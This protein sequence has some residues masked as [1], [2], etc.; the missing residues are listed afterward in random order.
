MFLGRNDLN[1]NDCL[2]KSTMAADCISSHYTR[3]TLQYVTNMGW[4]VMSEHRD[5]RILRHRVISL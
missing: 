3:Y 1:T 4:T 5:G 2:L